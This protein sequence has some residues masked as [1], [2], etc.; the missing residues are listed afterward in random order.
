MNVLI[1]AKNLYVDYAGRD[2]LDIEALDVYAYDRIGLVGANGAGKSTLIKVL[3]G[4]LA[5]AE[6]EVVRGGEFA[7]IPQ[8]EDVSGEAA[9]HALLGKLGLSEVER[10]Y[11]SGG[12]ETRVK[13][14]EALSGAVHGLVADEPTS[15]L[16]REGTELLIHQL[17]HY[18][19]ALLLISHDRHFLDETVDKIWELKEGRITEYWGGYSDYLAA[20]EAERAAQAIHYK[21]FAAER[22]RLEK[23][24]GEK[25]SQAR[26]LEQKEKGAAKKNRSDAGGRLS[27]QKTVGS[28]QKKLHKAAKQMEQRIEAMGEVKPPE[29]LDSV[30]FRQSRTLELHNPFPITGYEVTKCLG[31]KVIFD[32]ASF[33]FPLG[34]KIAIT[35]GNGAGKSTLLRMIMNRD[36]GIVLAPKVEM[37]YFAQNGYKTEADEQ[38][39]AFMQAHSDYQVPE[40]RSVLAAMGFSSQDVRKRL[41]MLSGGERMKL[42]LARLLLGRYN[43]LLLDE[44]SNFLDLPAVEALETLLK[45]YT[46]TIVFVTH[47]HRM[48]QHTA[49][50][51]YEIKDRKLVQ[52]EL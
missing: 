7:Y 3:L 49:D 41:P 16:D 27:H 24:I 8:L 45:N 44:P 6:G 19:G 28:K 30:V 43:V 23:S 29:A 1:K 51:V 22:E 38:V 13:I 12:E 50:L 31:D 42:Q 46:G 35:G 32:Q 18:P 4:E 15:H 14:A 21:Q 26:K 5:P 20:K 33:Q 36:E 2:V 48:L 37:G 10:E 40:I 25:Q 17:K 47:D 11:R 9:D 52:T 39:L 34:A